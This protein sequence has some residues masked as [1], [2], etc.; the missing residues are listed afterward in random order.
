[1]AG[2][3]ATAADT[4]LWQ[5][6][7]AEIPSTRYSRDAKVYVTEATDGLRPYVDDDGLDAA[8]LEPVAADV[9]SRYFDGARLNSTADGAAAYDNLEHLE[10]YLKSRLTGASPPN[11]EAEQAHVTALVKTLTGVRLLADAAVQ[12]AEATIGPFRRDPLPAPE[13]EGLDDAFALLDAAKADLA[14]VDTMLRKANPEPA[15]VAAAKAWENGFAVLQRLG[16]TYE[17]DH[18]GDGVVD[19]VELRF[20]ASPLLTDSDGDGLTDKFEIYE[21]AG[22][23]WPNKADSDLDAVRDGDEDIDGDGLTNLKEQEL[24]TSP[25]DPDT[26]GDGVSDGAEVA[27][28]T[29]PLV[30]DQPRPPPTPGDGDPDPTEP[31]PTAT[32]TDGDGLLD[33]LEDDEYGTDKANPD[34]DADGL[35]D[36]AEVDT[37]L[38]DP[39]LADTDGDGLRDDYELAHAEDQGLDPAV[40]DEQISKWT[41]VGDFLLGMFAGEFTP[42]DSMAWLAGNL[43]SGGLSFIPVVGWIIGG[44]ADLRDAIASAIHADWVGAGLSILGIIPYGGD[45]AAIPAK[46]ARFA[47]KYLHRLDGVVRFVAK[48]DKIA[49]SVKTVAFKAI[50]LGNYGK[51]TD[52]GLTDDIIVRIAK[53]SRSSLAKLAD[54][55]SDPLHRAAALSERA[56]WLWSGRQGENWFAD[57]L[58]TQGRTGTRAPATFVRTPTGVGRYPDYVEDVAGGGQ[59]AHEVKVGL[60][61]YKDSQLQQCHADGELRRA[62]QFA[63][64]VWH[65]LPYA[66]DNALGIPDYLL[67]CLRMEGIP[68]T[69]HLPNAA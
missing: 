14:Q 33:V 20:G 11:G 67:E 66:R 44:A 23:T 46:A 16:I 42:R 55:L 31:V 58:A 39:T 26:D 41:Y 47:L 62:G 13:P 24:G 68:F 3:P 40:P 22:W 4:P 30:P 28:G 32:D 17:G 49:D 51:L 54:A 69:V 36:G 8:R 52:A 18:D 38:I 9:E 6:A 56:P 37:Y 50:L 57:L 2:Q 64:V 15:A 1:M 48:W 19:V 27:A 65:F 10:S 63:E 21:L 5:T 25:T 7:V 35:T 45:A 34:T 60:P 12:D 59:V 53:G 61:A 43:C 29:D